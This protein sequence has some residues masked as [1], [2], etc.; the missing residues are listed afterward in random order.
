MRCPDRQLNLTAVGQRAN[1]FILSFAEYLA[2]CCGDEGEENPAVALAKEGEAASAFADRSRLRPTKV[3]E[4]RQ[5]TPQLAAGLILCWVWEKA[6]ADAIV[7][8]LLQVAQFLAGAFCSSRQAFRTNADF[9]SVASF[10]G[11][12]HFVALIWTVSRSQLPE[13]H[14]SRTDRQRT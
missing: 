1:L 14:G 4:I 10:W 13:T 8:A 12:C 6:P 3:R 7:E 5:D 9:C 2:A 11:A